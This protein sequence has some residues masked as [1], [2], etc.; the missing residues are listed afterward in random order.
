MTADDP[1]RG[2]PGRMDLL[3][4]RHP[5]YPVLGAFS[6]ACLVG[7]FVTDIA[8]WQSVNVIWETFSDWLIT[9]GL[10]LA[11]FAIIA[12]LIDIVAGKYLRTLT[13]P[14]AIGYAFAV[15]LSLINAFVH[16]RDGYTAVV[17]TGLTLSALVV[18]ILLFTA[19]VDRAL[20]S[21]RRVGAGT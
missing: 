5:I 7:A 2:T 17:P 21:R 16:S 20:V 18:V 1:N 6:I 4:G 13:W 3:V 10:I 12:F 19:W 11:G 9:A 14:R 8:Y 15:L